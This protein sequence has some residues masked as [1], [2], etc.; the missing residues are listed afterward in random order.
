VSR[1][2]T[3]LA[4]LIIA[5]AFLWT[6][7]LEGVVGASK[8]AGATPTPVRTPA[9]VPTATPLPSPTPTPVPQPWLHRATLLTIYGRGFNNT[10]I[11]GRLGFDRSFAD[12]QRQIAPFL[13]GIRANNGGRRVLV[14]VH[15]IYA[16]ATPCAG[17]KDCLG[18]LDDA[19]TNIVRDYI[20]PA[21]RLGWLVVLDDQ[22]GL[23]NPAAEV[24]RII[25][26]GYLRYDNVAVALDPEFRTSAGQPTPGIPVGSVTGAELSRAAWLLNQYAAAH[27]VRH[28]RLLLVHQFQWGMIQNRQSFRLRW[29][30]VDPVIVADGF[31]TPGIKAHV[32]HDLLGPAF[33]TIPWRGLKLFFPNPLERAGHGDSPVMTWAQVFGRAPAFE[34]ARRFSVWPP[35]NVVIV[36]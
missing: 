5:G 20:E 16:I 18:Y 32:Y 36:A 29:R 26:K 23:S 31:G 19:G 9:P 8:V 17:T 35:P 3:A 28:H 13:A 1:F 14:A 15:L 33:P 7:N 11:L 30:Y 22:L 25:A 2:V 21:A 4:V 27:P 12:M 34:G 10:P 24:Q 6:L